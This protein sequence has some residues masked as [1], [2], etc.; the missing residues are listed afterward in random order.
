MSS[1]V[2]CCPYTGVFSGE[3]ERY[4]SWIDGPVPTDREE[5]AGN[6]DSKG[7][8]LERMSQVASTTVKK[9]TGIPF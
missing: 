5:E 3:R 7:L 4:P 1:V 8:F 9:N 6:D 2:V